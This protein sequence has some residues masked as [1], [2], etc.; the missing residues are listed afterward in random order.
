MEPPT[1]I[2]LLLNLKISRAMPP[3]LHIPSWRAK[4]RY[5]TSLWLVQ[6]Q[7][8]V[9]FTSHTLPS[10]SSILPYQYLGFYQNIEH[11]QSRLNS[12]RKYSYKSLTKT[13]PHRVCYFHV[14][15]ECIHQIAKTHKYTG[16]FN[17]PR[18]FTHNLACRNLLEFPPRGKPSRM[19]S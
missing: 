4:G 14:Q 8:S 18:Y 12:Q 9:P 19:Q 5:I 13:T 10:S 17:T 1:D 11:M 16:L 6:L 2:Y 15:H 7:S 3:L